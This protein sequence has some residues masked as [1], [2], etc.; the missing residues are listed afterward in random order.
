MKKIAFF[1]VV[2]SLLIVMTGC[3]TPGKLV[4]KETSPTLP[5]V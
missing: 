5:N 3:Q 1:S 4:S 2:T